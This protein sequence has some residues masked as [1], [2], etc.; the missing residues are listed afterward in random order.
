M[1]FPVATLI[2]QQFIMHCQKFH[3]LFVCQS[4]T[5]FDRMGNNEISL[6]LAGTRIYMSPQLTIG[7]KLALIVIFV[8][9]FIKLSHHC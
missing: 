4:L 3:K 8:F 2:S 7:V 9:F 5:Y 1:H 6:L